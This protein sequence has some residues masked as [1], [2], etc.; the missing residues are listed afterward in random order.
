MGREIKYP[1]YQAVEKLAK[2]N[3]TKIPSTIKNHFQEYQALIAK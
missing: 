2:S 3:A 1:K